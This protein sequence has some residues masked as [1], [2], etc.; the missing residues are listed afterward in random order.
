MALTYKFDSGKLYSIRETNLTLTEASNNILQHLPYKSYSFH[1]DTKLHFKRVIIKSN[2]L[3]Y[4]IFD[5]KIPK[6][7]E[8]YKLGEVYVDP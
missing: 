7:D 5:K 2:E 1:I 3:E 6:F 8:C 4:H